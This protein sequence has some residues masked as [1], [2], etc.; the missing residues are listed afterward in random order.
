[1][2]DSARVPLML[3]ESAVGIARSCD[4]R[5]IIV[6][7]D[8]LPDIEALPSRTVLVDRGGCD[9][10]VL[11]RLTPTAEAVLSVPP[12]ELDRLGQIRLA[13]ILAMTDRLIS[14]GDAV[15]FLS[16][17]FRG[18]ID[19]L[20][21]LE[22]GAEYELIDTTEQ[23]EMDEHIRRAV[24]QKV[25]ELSL[26]LGRHGREGR[27]VGCL[28][29]V[30]DHESVL[31]HVEQMVLNPFKGYPDEQRN[32]LDHGV[33]E[34]VKEFSSIDGAFVVRGTGVVETAGARLRG[35]SNANLPSGL[36][37]RHAAAAAITGMTRSVAVSVSQ[38]DGAVRVWRAGRMVAHFTPAGIPD[39]PR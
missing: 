21:V 10:A 6:A 1:M 4:A 34:T 2:F 26:D 31:S 22:I 25:L 11:A 29:V 3:L 37:S 32:L 39:V 8:A 24:F 36:G 33:A 19:T 9:P 23:P 5:A 17:P 38:S 28:I 18:L 12:V 7:A 35:L 30:G 16:G 20:L 15:V 14:L 13:G 27:R